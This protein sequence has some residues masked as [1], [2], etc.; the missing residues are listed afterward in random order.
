MSLKERKN[1]Q[2]W[3]FSIPNYLLTV[4]CEF[5]EAE[6]NLVL[7]PMDALTFLFNFNMQSEIMWDQIPE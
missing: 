1:L 7:S 5:H 4:F 6:E 3:T 2:V